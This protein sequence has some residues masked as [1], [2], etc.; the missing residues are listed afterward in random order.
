MNYSRIDV[1]ASH[2]PAG[3]S[4]KNMGKITAKI[5]IEIIY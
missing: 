4:V 1:Y 5:N 2:T 3:T